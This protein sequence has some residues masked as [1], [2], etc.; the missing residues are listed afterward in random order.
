MAFALVSKSRSKPQGSVRPVPQRKSAPGQYAADSRFGFTKPVFQPSTAAVTTAPVI[1]AKLKIGEPNDKIEQKADQVVELT[2]NRGDSTL[3][4]AVAMR[5]GLSDPA[6]PAMPWRSSQSGILQ[7][8]CACGGAAGMSGECEECSKKQRLGLQTKLTVNEPGD[9]YEQEADRIADQVMA[10]PAHPAVSGAPPRIQRFSGQSNG[11]MDAAPASVDQALASPGRP[12][13]PALRQ[14]ME[15][16]FGHDFSQV[17]VHSGAAAEQSARDVNAHAYTVGHNIVFGAGRFAPGTHEGRRLIAHELT[18]VVQQKGSPSRGIIIRLS[19]RDESF[20]IRG[21]PADSKEQTSF[22]FFNLNDATVPESER[23]KI[24]HFA[25]E[26][27]S[28]PNIN[29]Y[30]YASE[31]GNEGKNTDLISDRLESVRSAL[32]RNF[33]GDINLIPRPTAS[34]QQINYRNFRSVEMS[35]GSSSIGNASSNTRTI[36][37]NDEQNATIDENKISAIG[38]IDVAIDHLNAFKSDPS[39]NTEVQNTLD[40]NFRSHSSST[41]T[42]L[43]HHLRQIKNDLSGLTGNSRRQCSTPEYGPC[44]SALALARRSQIILCPKYFLTSDA[45]RLETLLHEMC[46]Y[47]FFETNDRAYRSERV[48]PFLSTAEALDNAESIAIFI[49]EMNLPTGGRIASTL[50]TPT[51]G[52]DQRLRH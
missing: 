49:S 31:E 41:V 2:E 26:H 52:Y 7:R 11:Q 17:R 34:V 24:E 19:P 6:T 3:S 20:V 47:A 15:Q 44:T 13:E 33:S 38:K 46:H 29:L 23:D 8:K 37:C 18:H 9:I 36:N 22:V 25:T 39:S 40:N 16:R 10:T 42:T 21:L 51:F 48:L 32:A 30:G 50:S 12:L 45:T 4:S 1:Q 35:L 28:A 27:I 43:L 14:D 5:H